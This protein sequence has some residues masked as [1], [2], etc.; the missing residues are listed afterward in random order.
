MG[1]PFKYTPE[2]LEQKFKEYVIWNK[3]S[4]KFYKRELLKSG[5]RAGEIVD[6][7]VTPPLTIVGFCVFCDISKAI[8]FEWLSDNNNPLFDISMRIREQ[9]EHNQ[10][11]GA[12]LDLFNPSIVAR[13]NG[14][15]DTVNIESNLQPVIN[16]ALPNFAPNF[17]KLQENNIQEVEFTEVKPIELTEL[18]TNE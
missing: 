12:A 6:I 11:S 14:L 18:N 16:I 3:E 9:I 2:Q 1:R 7:D 8:F 17:A 10:I 13:L 15:T 4:N 5:E